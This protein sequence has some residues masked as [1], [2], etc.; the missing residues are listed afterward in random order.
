MQGGLDEVPESFLKLIEGMLANN[1]ADR[2]TT[3][4]V[5]ASEWYNG[6]VPDEAQVHETMITRKREVEARIKA[7]KQAKKEQKAGA[8]KEYTR[9]IEDDETGAFED[10]ESLELMKEIR[11]YDSRVQQ[12]GVSTLLFTD[13]HPLALQEE[14]EALQEEWGVF[15]FEKKKDFKY[16]V[17]VTIDRPAVNQDEDEEESKGDATT[18][19]VRVGMKVEV[20]QVEGEKR[21]CLEFTRMREAS[22][23]GKS[24]TAIDFYKAFDLAAEVFQN[25]ANDEA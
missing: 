12:F 23:E 25:I 16:D 8:R 22:Q 5:M 15:Q 9:G 13:K 17:F 19:E 2:M 20:K 7:E 3:A 14:F 1:V 4:Q 21:W 10:E 6:A 11:L 18:E 24:A